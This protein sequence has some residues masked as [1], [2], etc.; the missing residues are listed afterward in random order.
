[1]TSIRLISL[2][3]AFID[4][5]LS[6]IVYDTRWIT[7]PNDTKCKRKILKH[8]TRKIKKKIKIRI[9]KTHRFNFYYNDCAL[10]KSL[11]NNFLILLGECIDW[12]FSFKV[13]LLLDANKIVI[14]C[15]NTIDAGHRLFIKTCKISFDRRI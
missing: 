10:L 14:P 12:Y 8:L 9:R 3:E 13:S 5:C 11:G 7:I 15:Q 6:L 2:D 1:M 4:E